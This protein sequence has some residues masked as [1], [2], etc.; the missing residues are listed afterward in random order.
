MSF[1]RLLHPILAD[2]DDGGWGRFRHE[3]VSNLDPSA[4]GNFRW[5]EY[6]HGRKRYAVAIW[7]PSSYFQS[8]TRKSLD[9]LIFYSPTTAE[10]KEYALNRGHRYPYGLRKDAVGIGQPYIASLGQSYLFNGH[11][12]CY[13]LLAAK[14]KAILLMPINDAGDW[15]PFSDCADA[16]RFINEIAHHAHKH[17]LLEP[18]N[19]DPK[20]PKIRANLEE[21]NACSRHRNGCGGCVQQ[22]YQSSDGPL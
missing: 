11:F 6:Q 20:A 3:T 10:K 15:G 8:G 7:M 9:F 17:G 5:L 1:R 18:P 22:R 21:A 16:Y 13:Q 19:I 4:E 2:P 14:K 12:L